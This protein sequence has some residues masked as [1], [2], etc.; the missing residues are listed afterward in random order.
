MRTSKPHPELA[1][2]GFQ[3]LLQVVR[4]VSAS[5]LDHGLLHL[6]EVRASQLNGCAYCMDMHA[7][8]ALEGGESQRRLNLLAAWREAPGFSPRE[9][10]A[11]AWTEALTELG[12][13]G[14][15]DALYAAT[16]E[17]FS[18][19]EVVDLTYAIALIN[20]WNRLGVGL[21][22]DLPGVPA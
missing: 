10:A 4:H 15:D 5:G 9:R 16:R 19:Q 11:L 12:R 2:K 8:A 6:L 7:T 18:E 17:H 21:Q 22:P 3:G 20:A 1:P 13:H 14:V